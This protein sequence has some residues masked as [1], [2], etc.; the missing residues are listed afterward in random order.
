[1]GQHLGYTRFGLRRIP[2]AAA[3]LLMAA[4]SV[5]LW[6]TLLRMLHLKLF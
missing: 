4:A 2:R 3:V 5:C 1:M 6:I